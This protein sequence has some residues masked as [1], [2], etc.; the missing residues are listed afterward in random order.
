MQTAVVRERCAPRPAPYPECRNRCAS[1]GASAL[2]LC[3]GPT[4]A[5]GRD[6]SPR[7]SSCLPVARD[8][9]R[10]GVQDPVTPGGGGAEGPLPSNIPESSAGAWVGLSPLPSAGGPLVADWGRGLV[11]L[12][13]FVAQ[14]L[15]EFADPP[16][17]GLGLPHHAP[18]PCPHTV[19]G[20]P[21]KGS[22]VDFLHLKGSFLQG[23]F[24]ALLQPLASI[25]KAHWVMGAGGEALNTLGH[26]HSLGQDSE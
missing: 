22:Q 11:A 9:A 16:R 12:P 25:D 6:R 17:A 4:V 14:G 3:S 19:P 23:A 18:A 26:G 8:A 2:E 5:R 21:G 1:L 24:R 20:P 15:L 7:N 10:P 13:A